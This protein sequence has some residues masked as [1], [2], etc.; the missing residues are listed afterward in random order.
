ME[1]RH[2]LLLLVVLNLHMIQFGSILV[3]MDFRWPWLKQIA[4]LAFQSSIF[5]L[6]SLWI[7]LW[8]YLTL[9]QL[10]LGFIILIYSSLEPLEVVSSSHLPKWKTP[11]RLRFR[12]MLILLIFYLS[13]P[14]ALYLSPVHPIQCFKFGI[15]PPWL[16]PPLSLMLITLFAPLPS[17]LILR[18]SLRPM[19]RILRYILAMER[20]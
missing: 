19:K 15:L 7:T 13:N 20:R 9:F 8:R 6:E 5:A 11:P 14:K 10:S 17:H 3:L 4:S 2:L 1:A 12:F 18:S 16:V